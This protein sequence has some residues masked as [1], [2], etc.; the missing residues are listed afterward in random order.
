MNIKHFETG[1]QKVILKRGRD[2][3]RRGH[4]VNLFEKIEVAWQAE[5]EGTIVLKRGELFTYYEGD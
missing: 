3:F 4:V 5:V 2:Y 1:I